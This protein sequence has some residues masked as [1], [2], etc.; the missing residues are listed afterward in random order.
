MDD[1]KNTNDSMT[2][3]LFL[4][5]SVFVLIACILLLKV[6]IKN[7]PSSS[8][9]EPLLGAKYAGPHCLPKSSSNLTSARPFMPGLKREDIEH[10]YVRTVA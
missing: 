3:V 6:L 2:P 5:I 1:N 9:T 8:L 7:I 10:L 4:V